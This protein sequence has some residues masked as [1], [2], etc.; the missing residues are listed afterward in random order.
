MIKK[1][2]LFLL[3][4]MVSMVCRADTVPGSTFPITNN[5]PIWA[6]FVMVDTNGNGSASSNTRSNLQMR[7]D[8]LTNRMTDIV[9]GTSSNYTAQIGQQG[10]NYVNGVSNL[11]ANLSGG[12]AF[13]VTNGESS[14]QVQTT[15]N[16]M[17]SG[18]VLSVQPGTYLMSSS[19][20]ITNANVVIEGNGAE[21]QFADGLTNS[22]L[23]TS[24]PFGKPLIIRNLNF[25]GR[26]FNDFNSIAYSNTLN[27]SYDPY[28][29]AFWTNRTGLR[30]EV[31]GGVVVTGCRFYGWS[32]NGAFFFNVNSNFAYQTPRL[33]Y[34]HNQSFSNFVS[35]MAVSS[36]YDYPGYA[37]SDS[38]LWKTYTCEYAQI[39]DNTFASSF[40]G[41][42]AGA[43]NDSV[44]N[45]QVQNNWIGLANFTGNNSQHGNYSFNNFN[46]CTIGIAAESGNGGNYV[47]NMI[48]APMDILFNNVTEIN[49][50][51]NKIGVANL[52]FTNNCSG[53]I[54]LNQYLAST[55]WGTNTVGQGVTTNFT[56][57]TM[58]VQGN[59]SEDGLNGDGSFLSYG[60]LGKNTHITNAAPT[61]VTIGTTDADKWVKVYDSLG[62][63][64]GFSP[65]W[66]NH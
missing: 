35:F 30:A 14:A 29:S 53:S 43:G 59:V 51:A 60:M 32:G 20:V 46:H 47:G 57:S 3:A 48:L 19:L 5:P 63:A 21:W 16:S 56:G 44:L 25:N 61:S 17:T 41:V 39:T 8:A 38:S 50:F 54:V 23:S 2:S 4:A 18:G 62:N 6:T 65:V 26:T 1:L 10:T 55:V 27:N 33:I 15:L 12:F 13:L 11:L 36:S 28:Y 34:T 40:I 22:L 45:N 58:I 9:G 31:S 42:A 37:S 7:W 66:I 24:T 49:F 64:I 52:I